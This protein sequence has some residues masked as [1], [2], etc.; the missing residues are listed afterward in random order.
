MNTDTGSQP[1]GGGPS[2]RVRFDSELRDL[3]IPAVITAGIAGGP[4]QRREMFTDAAIA[5]ARQ[6]E[7]QGI[8]P[9]PVR[10][11]AGYVRSAGRA[12]AQ[13]LPQPLI[14]EIPARLARRWAAASRP[15]GDET[16]GDAV[17]R[18]DAFAQWLTMV[19]AMLDLRRSAHHPGERESR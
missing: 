16:A 3:D 17:D 5:A 10:F 11:L 19:A 18:D 1:G 8:G 6:L 15:P 4:A 14:G 12:A 13:A 9:Y 7:D 2:A